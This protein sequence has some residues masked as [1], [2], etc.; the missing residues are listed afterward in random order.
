M[1]RT[2]L[3]RFTPLHLLSLRVRLTP[4]CIRLCAELAPTRSPLLLPLCTLHT[5]P[6]SP[7]TYP[8]TPAR[9]PTH[10]RPHPPSLTHP[11]HTHHRPTSAPAPTPRCSPSL[12]STTTNSSR[13]PQS[14]ARSCRCG[15]DEGLVS[16]CWPQAGRW[17][18]RAGRGRSRRLRWGCKYQLRINRG[19]Q[20]AAARGRHA[21]ISLPCARVPASCCLFPCT[22]HCHAAFALQ[23]MC[24]RAPPLPSKPSC[25]RGAL[26]LRPA[27]LPLTLCALRLC[28]YLCP[29]SQNGTL[30]CRFAAPTC[31]N[32]YHMIRMTGSHGKSEWPTRGGTAWRDGVGTGVGK[33][34]RVSCQGRTQSAAHT[35]TASSPPLHLPLPPYQPPIVL[36]LPSRSC[37]PQTPPVSMQSSILRRSK[38]ALFVPCCAWDPTPNHECN[39]TPS[40]F[41]CYNPTR[42]SRWSTVYHFLN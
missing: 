36:H 16:G 33:R 31:W 34:S 10:A 18:R 7:P 23:C 40:W 1:L 8:H 41:G 9:T 28:R 15:A 30:M 38:V 27:P 39:N 19:G 24:P 12:P 26:P 14:A 3:R 5:R 4:R 2:S 42:P 11:H 25:A 6:H 37:S 21:G 29:P 17:D 20:G 35:A 13:A 32:F 22:L